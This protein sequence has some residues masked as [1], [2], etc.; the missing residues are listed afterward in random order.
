MVDAD[1]TVRFKNQPGTRT[2][3]VRGAW[4]Q[5]PWLAWVATPAFAAASVALALSLGAYAF[6]LNSRLAMEL[7][8]RARLEASVQQQA[9]QIAA[10]QEL[11]AKAQDQKKTSEED[12]S[13]LRARLAAQEQETVRL[14]AALAQ[15][16]ELLA[17][18]QSAD[19]KVVALAGSAK[20]RSASGLLLYDPGS[21]KAF[22]YG[23]NL[24]PLQPG[25]TYQLW[26]IAD[27]PVN[28]GVFVADSGRKGRMVTQPLP[29]F[30]RIKQFVVSVETEG[31]HSQPSGATYLVSRR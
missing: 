27:K 13:R 3:S 18:L 20:A 12:A 31:A 17:F 24:P 16:D 5:L 28:A 2:A 30:P 29:E 6:H 11:L 10:T 15:R 22:F 14:S 7:A 9:V 23:F 8:E 25:K 4:I 21:K 19:A 1:T 26:A